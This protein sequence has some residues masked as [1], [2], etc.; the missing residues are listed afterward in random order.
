MISSQSS[1]EKVKGEMMKR[2]W[3]DGQSEAS[4]D[5]QRGTSLSSTHKSMG[6]GVN[7]T[8]PQSPHLLNEDS[9]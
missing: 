2:L 5:R 6:K 9:N 8:E 1:Q 4:W 7:S 3:G